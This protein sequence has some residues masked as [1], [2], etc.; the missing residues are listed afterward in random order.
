MDKLKENIFWI[1][2]GGAGIA[3]LALAW[4]LVLSPLYGSGADT[5]GSKGRAIGEI[6]TKVG[7]FNKKERVPTTPYLEYL[8]H[9]VEILR[10]DHNDGVDWYNSRRAR[11]A[12][13]FEGPDEPNASEFAARYETGVESLIAGYRQKFE[14]VIP[15]DGDPVPDVDVVDQAEITQDRLSR[16]MKEFWVTSEIFRVATDLELGEQTKSGVPE[17]V[18]VRK[19]PG[20][21]K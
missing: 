18:D 1:G 20:R 13:F 10:G 5:L 7:S 12:E 11:F 19:E 15:E 21:E 6:L 16:I 14:I 8:E 4:L 3:L 17:S 2:L 9:R